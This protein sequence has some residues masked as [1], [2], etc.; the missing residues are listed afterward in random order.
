MTEPRITHIVLVHWKSG[1]D[2]ESAAELERLVDGL[3]GQIPGILSVRQ[4][5]S[6]SPENLEAGY[7]WGLV[8]E[9]ADAAA[10]DGYLPHPAHRPVAEL[11]GR[12]AER[13]VVFD[14]AED[15]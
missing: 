2:T 6:V 4:G 12:G 11:I 14:L 15:A 3:P 9:F 8:V 1:F 7:E 13:L 10:R 5:G